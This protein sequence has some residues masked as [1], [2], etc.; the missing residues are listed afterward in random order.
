MITMHH[1]KK[2][3]L[4]F[5]MLCIGCTE[6]SNSTDSSTS[7]STDLTTNEVII[8]NTA[9]ASINYTT[10]ALTWYNEQNNTS[11]TSINESIIELY[12]SQFFTTETVTISDTILCDDST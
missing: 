3:L 2:L 1:I 4:Y 10:L 7:T 11:E 9:G 8:T 6:I 5:L 12:F